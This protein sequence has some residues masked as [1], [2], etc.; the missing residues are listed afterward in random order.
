MY[1]FKNALKSIFRS[2]GRNILMG[3]IVFVIAISTCVALS[4]RESAKE[5][6]DSLL[7]SI[8]ITAQISVD[9][10]SMMESQASND[11]GMDKDAIKEL[12]SNTSSLTIEEM[13]VYA[14]ANSVKDFYY[15]LTASLDGSDSFESIDSSSTDSTD[16]TD[17]QQMQGQISGGSEGTKANA[18]GSGR[19]GTQGD[20]TLIGY[21]SDIGMTN[22]ISGVCTITDGALFDEGTTESV[23]VISDELALY[24][25]MSVGDTIT[26]TNPNNTEELIELKIVGIYN[27]SESTATSENVMG[28]FMASTDSANQIYMS[29]NALNSIISVSEASAVVTTEDDQ[30]TSQSTALRSQVSGTYVFADIASY[31]E[32]DSQARALGLSDSYL[33]SSSDLAEYESSLTPLENLSNFATYFFIIVLIIGGVIL[34]VLNIFNIRE[35]KYE[36]GVLTAMGMKKSKVAL[37]FVS[38]LFLVTIIAIIIGTSAGAAISLPVTNS[39]LESQVTAQVEA[40]SDLED[41]FGRASGSGSPGVGRQSIE[42]SNTTDYIA[43]V[44]SATNFTVIIQLMGIGIILT[45][46]ASMAAVVFILRYEPLKILSSRD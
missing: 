44:S 31:E 11:E 40:A 29:Y 45:L 22:F 8:E 12:F 4:I 36:I 46:V 9:R 39:L 2:K 15:T 30:T 18:P 24:N 42:A 14:D 7:D 3:I 20:F 33:I 10:K 16:S 23:C 38:E 43:E 27:N 17:T 6:K 19:M 34:I 26:L 32:F 13:L 37:Q 5:A 1:I 25:S 28:G 21:S 41:N 35:R